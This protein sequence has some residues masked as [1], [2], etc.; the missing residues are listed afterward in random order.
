[1]SQFG[2]YQTAGDLRVAGVTMLDRRLTSLPAVKLDVMNQ[3]SIWII[4]LGF[5]FVATPFIG[6]QVSM[7]EHVL[8]RLLSQSIQRIHKYPKPRWIA[9]DK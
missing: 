4:W 8:W 7:V 3:Q 9:M 1:M 5:E 2:D 6:H